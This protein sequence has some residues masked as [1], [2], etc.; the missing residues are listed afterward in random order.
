MAGTQAVIDVANSPSFEDKAVLEFF[1]TPRIVHLLLRE[2]N[3]RTSRDSA[4]SGARLLQR[5]TPPG[6]VIGIESRASITKL[7]FLRLN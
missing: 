6:R 2:S 7:L 1:E 3:G 5:H 4:S